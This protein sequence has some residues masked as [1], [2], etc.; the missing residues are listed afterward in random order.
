MV[1]CVMAHIPDAARRFFGKVGV[2]RG[3][4]RDRGSMSIVAGLILAPLVVLT[5]GSVLTT[6]HL[7]AWTRMHQA[8]VAAVL[9]VTK[10]GEDA[11][12]EERDLMVRTWLDEGLNALKRNDVWTPALYGTQD[13]E[14]LGVTWTPT[15]L[16][17]GFLNAIFQN[18]VE[19]TVRAERFYR[20]IEAVVVLDA[21]MSA[22]PDTNREIVDR[23]TKKLFR[24]NESADDVR[25]SLVNFG[26][27]VNIGTEYAD[28]LITPE[29]RKLAKPGTDLGVNKSEE[30]YEKQV[31]TLNH[32]N[33]G[34]VNDLLAAGGPASDW[35][36][37][38]VARPSAYPSEDA[39]AYKATIEE[40]PEDPAKG[41]TLLM[42][43]GRSVPT[44]TLGP[45]VYGTDTTVPFSSYYLMMNAS[46]Q[47]SFVYGVDITRLALVPPD[48]VVESE[49]TDYN[50]YE[51]WG[52]SSQWGNISDSVVMW[53]YDCPPMPMLVGANSV[54][55]VEERMK[56]FK[57]AWTTGQDEGLAWALRVLAPSYSG[58][59]EKGADFPAPY[60]STTEKR[61]LITIGSGTTS[62]DDAYVPLCEL[63]RDNG[64]QT[65][66]IV[67]DGDLR[68]EDRP[69]LQE[70]TVNGELVEDIASTEELMEIFERFSTR[71]YRVRLVDSV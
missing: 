30:M 65:Y 6:R 34:L 36:M 33:P 4:K 46:S 35:G 17:D 18:P 60:H 61:V 49:K 64:I 2:G 12:A 69:K 23:V 8:Q 62:D 44:D 51:D 3:G 67:P 22:N 26:A 39:S 24:G 9:A 27:F 38:C 70:C 48:Y 7:S 40:A 10:E 13:T 43:D 50:A 21:S 29:S 25:L 57:P 15:A 28:K 32:Y 71:H 42:A 58:I 11:N 53:F 19:D 45:E 63:A 37:A 56:M 55:D 1:R 31:E 41:F 54:K 16:L 68:S 5:V 52:G 20:P 47:G 66:L 59:W 14:L